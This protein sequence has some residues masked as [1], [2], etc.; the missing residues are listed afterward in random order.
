MRSWIVPT[1][2]VMVGEGVAG[3][4]V[5]ITPTLQ[6]FSSLLSAVLVLAIGLALRWKNGSRVLAI[7]EKEQ[8]LRSAEENRRALAR[9][10]H[11]TIAKDLAHVAVLAQDVAT[12]H[13]EISN[14]L[15]PLVTAATEALRRI[16]PMI[17]SIDTAAREM[18]LSKVAQQVVQMLNTR[19]IT[20]DTDIAKGLDNM[21]TRQ[22]HLIGALAIRECGSNILK[23]APECSEAHLVID[24]D[25]QFGTL[26][27]S[28]SNEIA[29]TPQVPG[30]SSG[31]GL[32]NLGEKVRS[33]GGTMEVSNLNHQWLIYLTIPTGAHIDN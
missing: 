25:V 31:Y 15:V 33:E 24:V 20:L 17:L 23:Y 14:E 4:A 27:I 18:P 5:S 1:I 8:T 21:A 26:M 30:M 6:A 11:D 2:L 28:L 10:L 13:P 22:Q 29:D 12:R 7:Q 32:V 9:Q 16:R 3:T 19:N